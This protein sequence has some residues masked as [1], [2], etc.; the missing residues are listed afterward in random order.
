[1]NINKF[2]DFMDS[3]NIFSELITLEEELSLMDLQSLLSSILK[4]CYLYNN[5][6]NIDYT[7]TLFNTYNNKIFGINKRAEKSYYI[8]RIK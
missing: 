7:T 3:P 1:M 4:H 6:C 8:W 2:I 5:F